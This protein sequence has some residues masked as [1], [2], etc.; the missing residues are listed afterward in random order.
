MSS[1]MPD[2]RTDLQ[3]QID[4]MSDQEVMNECVKSKL[5][6]CPVECSQ[7]KYKFE[8][9]YNHN[10]FRLITE[11]KKEPKYK[12]DLDWKKEIFKLYRFY[13]AQLREGSK[14]DFTRCSVDHL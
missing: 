12:K 14:I 7:V 2:L 4:D 10:T 3:K 8:V 5:Y 6:I 1:I 11:Y 13:Y 9:Q